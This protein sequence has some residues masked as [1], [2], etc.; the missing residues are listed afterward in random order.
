M[1]KI[2]LKKIA[3]AGARGTE[4]RDTGGAFGKTGNGVFSFQSFTEH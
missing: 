1:A 4:A 3:R 2:A